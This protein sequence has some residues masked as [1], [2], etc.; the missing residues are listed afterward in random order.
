MRVRGPAGKRGSAETGSSMTQPQLQQRRRRAN[1]AIA[2]RPDDTGVQHPTLRRGLYDTEYGNT[3]YVSGPNA[4]TAKDL[5]M[6]ERVPIECIVRETWHKAPVR[7]V[8]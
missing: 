6:N 7:E 4:K 5:D 3:A 2:G 8:R 1:P